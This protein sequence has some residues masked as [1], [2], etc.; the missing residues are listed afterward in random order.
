MELVLLLVG[1]AIGGVISHIYYRQSARGAE[2][3]HRE[4]MRHMANTVGRIEPGVN[5][6]LRAVEHIPGVKI[7]RDSF[8]NP[9][10]GLQMQGKF[11][12]VGGLSGVLPTASIADIKPAQE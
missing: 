6:L 7:A 8:D 9:T 12:P 5:A 11:V 10:G 3:Q 4:L 2:N 1:R